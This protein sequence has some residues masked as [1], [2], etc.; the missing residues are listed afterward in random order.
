MSAD[1]LLE[2]ARQEF[3]KHYDLLLCRLNI[4]LI[5]DSDST[6][7]FSNNFF[8]TNKDV[9]RILELLRKQLP[10]VVAEII[11]RAQQ[12]CK[13]RFNLLGYQDID[14]G[15]EIDWHADKL[16]GKRAPLTAWFRVPYLDFDLVGDAKIIWEL[17]R[18]QHLTVLAKAYRLTGNEHYARELFR[19]WYHW[20]EHNP[21]PLGINWASS[22]E[23]AFRSLSWLWVSYLMDGCPVVPAGFSADLR[24]ALIVSA[25]HMERFLSTYFSPNTHLLGE[26]VGLFFI[27]TLVSGCSSAQRW[28]DLGWRIILQ[29]ARRQV[30]PDGMHFEQSIYYHTYAIDLF[31]HS[32]LLADKNGLP[33]PKEFDETLVRMLEAMSALGTEGCLP[34]F[35]DDD[36][37][38]LFDGARN[39]TRDLLDPLATGAVLF[40]RPEFKH[41][42]CGVPEETVWLTG[43]AGIERLER[44]RC[45]GN[46]K[47][48]F[49]M[50]SSGIYAMNSANAMLVIDAGAQGTGFGGHGHADAL[51]LQLIVNSEPVLIDPGTYVYVNDTERN[52]FRETTAHNTVVVDGCSQAEPFTAFKWRRLPNAEV[53]RWQTNSAFDLFAASHDG[54]SRLPEPVIHRRDVFGLKSC[55]WLVQDILKGSGVHQLELFWHFPAGTLSLTSSGALFRSGKKNTLALLLAASHRCSLEVVPDWYSPVYGTKEPSWTLRVC[56]QAQMPASFA[57]LLI[58]AESAA[59]PLGLFRQ[60]SP[61]DVEIRVRSYEYLTADGTS[62]RMFFPS[63]PGSWQSGTCRSDARFLHC[64]ERSVDGTYQFTLCEG[65]YLDVN[66]VRLFNAKSAVPVIS[67]AIDKHE[68]PG[69]LS[70]LPPMQ[71]SYYE[72]FPNRRVSAV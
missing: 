58:P 39:R 61:T 9:P 62:H 10:E 18:H 21:Y 11:G 14:H 7:Q 26:G 69:C 32:R 12:I 48:S 47:S 51:S 19:Q 33:V 23:I 42:D 37:G 43:T 30:K 1:E 52:R 40:N 68:C 60:I 15:A 66:G 46:R 27:G 53:H 45:T 28:Q 54:Y 31:L 50:T 22:L 70:T 24:R 65:T 34:R 57:T 29:E 35:G 5:Q 3:A 4:P 41:T 44:M 20:Q 17:N 38:R 25:R 56:T 72:T 8:F 64:V 55:F 49:A 13:H 63:S 71:S 6:P 2:R 59:A 67:F 16:H 36:G